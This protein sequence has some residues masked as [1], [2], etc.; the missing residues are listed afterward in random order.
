[1]QDLDIFDDEV[2]DL[3]I[4]DF[5]D[6]EDFDLD[7][8]VDIEQKRYINPGKK[9]IA[10]KPVKYRNALS[11]AR[12]IG[13]IK[14]DDRFYIFLDGN[15]VFGDFI[16]A[17]IIQNNYNVLEMTI[18]TLSMSE[19]NIDSLKNLFVGDYLQKLNLI[20]SDYFFTHERHELIPY[21]YKELDVDN[22]LQLSVARVHTKICLLK[23]ECGKKIIIHGS[24][25]L[26]TSKNVEQIVIERD[27]ELFDFN[28]SWHQEII[29]KY[30][31][32]NKTVG[33]RDLWQADQVFTPK[34]INTGKNARGAKRAQPK[35][36]GRKSP[37]EKQQNTRTQ[38]RSKGNGAW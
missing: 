28:D 2:Y 35:Q 22:K 21:L 31:T 34:S 11:L 16:E 8:S 19:N 1:M 24:A 27:D 9:G 38:S 18:S 3:D 32:I 30:K 26:R 5:E 33:A 37:Q 36:G 29:E 10:S 14:Q 12:K 15:F 7:F 25:N 4:S 23:T 20:V 17:W 6:L 13:D